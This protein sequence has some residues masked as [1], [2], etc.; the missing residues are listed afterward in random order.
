MCSYS[1]TSDVVTLEEILYMSLDY[2][3][4]DHYAGG[5]LAAVNTYINETI[6]ILGINANGIYITGLCSYATEPPT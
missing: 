6:Y 1:I 3:G 4:L 2:L 5:T